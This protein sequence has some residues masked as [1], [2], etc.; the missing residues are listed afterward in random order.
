[1][2]NHKTEKPDAMP[3]G[4]PDETTRQNAPTTGTPRTL[5]TQPDWNKQAQI[6]KIRNGN[7]E[8]AVL[9]TPIELFGDYT[10]NTPD[11][12]GYVKIDNKRQFLTACLIDT[13]TTT[14][15]DKAA[16]ET[17][18]VYMGDILNRLAT[19]AINNQ[20][21]DY[22]FTSEIVAEAITKTR[23]DGI[24]APYLDQLERMVTPT[25]AE[26]TPDLFPD[27]PKK[28]PEEPQQLSLQQ[29]QTIVKTGLLTIPRYPAPPYNRP[30]FIKI[31]TA[32]LVRNMHTADTNQHPN[33]K[34]PYPV[35]KSPH[36]HFVFMKLLDKVA[37]Q[38]PIT[39]LDKNILI[40][41][42]NLYGERKAAGKTGLQGGAIIT[43][44]DLIRLYRG[45]DAEAT[46][47][48][49]EIEEVQ[50]R[51]E[52]MQ[53][54]NVTFDFSQHFEY[55]NIG[56]DVQLSIPDDMRVELPEQVANQLPEKLKKRY[57][58]GTVVRFSYKGA[59]IHA[60]TIEVEYKGGR[61][62]KA[63]EILT[64]PIVYDYA[65]KIKQVQQV[66]T[67]L[68]DLRKQANSGRDI[69]IIK[70]YLVEQINAMKHEKSTRS[71]R[72][73]LDTL[74]SNLRLD[75][76][77]RKQ[78]KKRVDAIKQILSHFSETK[79]KHGKTFIAGFTEVKGFRNAVTAFDIQL[80][81]EEK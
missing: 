60:N 35:D 76:N 79:D 61:V 19:Q 15:T 26:D 62:A 40:A 31:P 4:T 53:K 10:K 5:P 72:I 38:Y 24:N 34:F 17:V 52:Y 66:E 12:I 22:Q 39:P 80:T 64:P 36:S 50:K 69:D 11:I 67:K 48:E 49:S 56:D 51:L 71:N 3:P 45:Y 46:V 54:L 27:M 75:I 44:A 43:A 41:L 58:R 18:A 25:A 6:Y 9:D 14:D 65:E 20:A 32:N 59:M 63:F 28:A 30:D 23:A 74:F 81:S 33:G 16:R 13:T 7:E 47:E 37:E 8:H 1:M 21:I 77:N 70:I 55:N 2:N 29:A 42:G 73:K 68:L 57:E 78:K